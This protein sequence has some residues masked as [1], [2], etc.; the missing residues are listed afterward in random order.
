MKP[1]GPIPPYFAASDDGQLTVGG[2][3]AE[4]LVE[5]SGGTPLI[6]YDNN[7]IGGQI[8]RLRAAMPDGLAIYYAV[9]ANPW[10]ELLNF[11]GRYVDGF[12]VVSRGE[13]ERLKR[14]DL[15]GI[16]MTFAG[17]GKR[18]D[19]LEAGI[20]AGATISVES[21]GEAARVILA[22]ERLGV[23]PKIAVRVN[24]PFVIEGGRVTMGA[25]PSPFGVDAEQAPSIVQGLIEADIDWRGLHIFAA[26]QY[27]D[28]GALI[29]AHRA[30]VA[31]AG[32]IANV[33]GLPLPELN[34]GG[35]FDIPCFEGDEPLDI[36]RM[37]G[38]LHETLTHGPELLATTRISLELGR[39]L[40]GEA[41]VYLTRVLDR[42]TSC[43]QTFLTT[44]GGGHHLL[45]ATGCL[46]ERGHGNWPLAVATRYGE[47]PEEQVTVTGCL[48][49]PYDTFGDEVMLPRAE[50]GDLIAI[51][52]AG[53]YGL[54]ASPQAWESR[55]AAREILV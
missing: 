19:E 14:A 28:D 17:P 15:A 47:P 48:A 23:R 35:G 1:I 8:A 9:S 51:F 44:D 31:C 37:A 26:A 27:L 25:R 41:G 50:P 55:P 46:L 42:T 11:L 10:E 12:R 52:N 24:P 43:G 33:L 20:V 18:D 54:T 30:I 34:L 5:A 39:W 4:E 45:R 38:A 2:R 21:E 3:P 29:E 22:G 53:A 13:L 6:A 32:D 16:A 40:V 7:I 49:T 36:Y